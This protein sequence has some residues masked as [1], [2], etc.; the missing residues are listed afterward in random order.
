MKRISKSLIAFFSMFILSILTYSNT[1]NSISYR[2]GNI[3]VKFDDKLD[4]VNATYDETV[5][6]LKIDLKIQILV[7]MLVGL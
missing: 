1:I 7:I 4:L 2:N 6:L 3:V 5:P